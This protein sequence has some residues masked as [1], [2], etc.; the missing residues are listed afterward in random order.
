MRS[1][2]INIRECSYND[3]LFKNQMNKYVSKKRI[4]TNGVIEIVE[5]SI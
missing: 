4:I 3:K 2:V 5:K 1:D